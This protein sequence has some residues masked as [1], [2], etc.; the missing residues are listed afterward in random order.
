MEK[1]GLLVSMKS[2]IGVLPYQGA[3]ARAG[4][5]EERSLSMG[6]QKSGR[7]RGK[8]FFNDGIQV[9]AA[10]NEGGRPFER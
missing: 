3:M 6:D 10:S 7:V 9:V 1:T 5:W 8:E 2:A 4:E